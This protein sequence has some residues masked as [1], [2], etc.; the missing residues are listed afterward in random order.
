[1]KIPWNKGKKNIYTPETI[2]RMSLARIGKKHT[3]EWKKTAR[4]RMLGEK[5][6]F[7]G[8][9]HTPESLEKIRESSLKN[10][11][12]YWKGKK[13][14]M[15][16]LKNP[17]VGKKISEALIGKKRGP[18]SQEHKKK[19]S[20]VNG[21]TGISQRTYKRYYHLRDRKYMD[22]RN[23]VFIRDNWTCQTCNKRGCYL[24]P[25]HIKGWA[26]YPELRYEVENGVTL[27]LECHRLTRKKH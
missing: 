10:P 15:P 13:R 23:G 20:I 2:K 11:R 3:D 19:I 22:W 5:N 25:H 24:E 17:L 21:G 6:H 26:K 12:R 27:C 16:W 4:E 7:Y 18:L 1:M 9:K 8:K 14:V